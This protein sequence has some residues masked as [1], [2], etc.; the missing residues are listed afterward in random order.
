MPKFTLAPLAKTDL[1]AIWNYISEFNE[2]S[3]NK[4]IRELSE[5]FQLLADNKNIGKRQD[6]FIVEMRMFPFKKYHIYY[7]PNDEGVEITEFCTARATS[8]AG[9]KIILKD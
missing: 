2:Q 9:L 6:N 4:F 5:K 3:A 1:K 7:F 8:K